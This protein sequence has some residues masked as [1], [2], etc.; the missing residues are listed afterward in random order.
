MHR[1][2]NWT[3]E[4]KLFRDVTLSGPTLAWICEEDGYCTYLSPGWHHFTGFTDGEGMNWLNCIHPDD[5]IKARR[6]FFE[7][8]DSQSKYNIDYRL[9]RSDGRYTMAVAHGVPYLDGAG[10]YQGI[11]GITTPA[12]HYQSEASFIATVDERPKQRILSDRER[13]VLGLFAQGHSSETA[14]THLGIA[15][16][17]VKAHVH[18]ATLKLKANN[19]LHAVV[20]ALRLNEISA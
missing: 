1:Q 19:R 5:R 8:N 4:R 6:A 2:P 16:A 9:M 11:F 13:E 12:E 14:G 7:A 10:K 18:S 17:T 15:E 3:A 20:L